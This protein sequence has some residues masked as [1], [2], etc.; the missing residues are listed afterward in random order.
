MSVKQTGKAL[1]QYMK[2]RGMRRQRELALDLGMSDTAI[3]R[4]FSGERFFSSK[5]ALRI[6][7]K[8]GVP[9]EELF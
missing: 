9:M 6:A 7:R 1:R 3:S 4:Y 8:I 2:A 5:T